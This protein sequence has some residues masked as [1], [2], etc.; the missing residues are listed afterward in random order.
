MGRPYTGWDGNAP[1]KRAGL[2]K[3]VQLICFLSGN[4]LWNN[5]TW[6]VRMMNNPNYKPRPSVHS[7]GRAADLS[8]RLQKERRRGGTYADCEKMLDFLVQYADQFR[9]EEIHDYHY[10]Q[11]GRGWRCDRAAWRVYEKNTIGSPGGDWIHVEISPEFADDP[12][13][14]DNLVKQIMAGEIAPAPISSPAPAP[15][16]KKPKTSAPEKSEPAVLRFDYPGQPIKLRSRNSVAVKLVQAAL[17]ITSDGKFGP[18][19]KGAVEA[20]QRSKGLVADGIVGQ[21][22]WTALFG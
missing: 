14:Y 6:S 20:F 11:W 10:G 8:W 16:P 2:E 3:F 15:A 19:T 1:G 5:G 4:T 7:T 18:Q 9:I 21:K 17:G 13:Y 22:T 12:G